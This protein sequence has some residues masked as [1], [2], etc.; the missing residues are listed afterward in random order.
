[1][2]ERSVT[3]GDGVR[4]STRSDGPA[5]ATPLLCCNSLGTGLDL[6]DPQVPGWSAHR[7]VLRFDQR[8]HGRSDAP[9]GPYELEE[10]GRDALA[11]LDA[12]EVAVADVC[13]LSLGGV[14]AQWLAI[15]HPERVDRVVLACTAARVGTEEAWRQRAE[16][17]RDGGT[18]AIADMVMERFF[19]PAFRE[20]DPRTVARF[21]QALVDTPDA[22]YI[23]SCLA[24]AKADLRAETSQLQAPTLV[25]AGSADE[26]TPPSVM[27]ELLEAIPSGRWAELEGVGHL[28]NLEDPAGFEQAVLDHLVRA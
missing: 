21:H 7:R 25:L 13:G 10:L 14:V 5:D 1:M 12:Y 22:G 23:G 18:S 28:A 27:R 26:A 24:L 15:N 19:S 3:T 20:R 17:V 8:G 11:V 9:D 4:L 2:N 16:A 6:W